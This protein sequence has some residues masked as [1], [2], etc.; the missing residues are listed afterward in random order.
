MHNHD[1]GNTKNIQLAFFLNLTF[2]IFEVIGGF[3]TN[4]MAILS[5]ALHDL[6]DSFALG[7]AWILEKKSQRG[8]TKT[9]TFGHKRFSLLSALINGLILLGGSFFILSEAIPRLMNPEHSNATGML[10]FA[11]VG[12]IVNGA[13]VLKL[14]KGSSMNVRIVATHL[15]EDVLGWGAVLIISIVMLFKDIHILD[16]ILSILITLYV[17]FN[18]IKNIKST[19]KIFLQAV[20]D[21]VDID[22]IENKI[23]SVK[24]VS[25][26]HH[27]HM[28]SEDG[29]HHVFTVHAVVSTTDISKILQIKNTIKSIL[30]K[31]SISHATVE[32]EFEEETCFMNSNSDDGQ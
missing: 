27:A 22:E 2:T 6:G 31:Y 26:V 13:A 3:Y 1:H 5:D 8:R 32:I 28:W 10:L 29:E 24:N 17:L 15:L 16:P 21:N 14:R 30:S 23:T 25:S 12:I 4:S 9:F 20:P 19:I 18:V 7:L 11:I